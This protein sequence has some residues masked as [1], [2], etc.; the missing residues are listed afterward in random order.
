MGYELKFHN[1]PPTA[2][3]RCAQ[4]GRGKHFEIADAFRS[5]PGKWAKW[6]IQMPKRLVYQ[7]RARLGEGRLTE[8]PAGQFEARTINGELWVRY[9]GHRARGGRRRTVQRSA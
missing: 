4:G 1:E 5:R 2:G 8:F 7:L 3:P 9:V 6:P